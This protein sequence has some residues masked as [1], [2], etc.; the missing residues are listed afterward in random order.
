L[1]STEQ[2]SWLSRAPVAKAFKKHFGDQVIV[3]GQHVW[4]LAE[5]VAINFPTDNTEALRTLERDNRLDSGDI[6]SVYWMKPEWQRTPNQL[7]A[8]LK[9]E[10]RSMDVANTLIE[11]GCRIEYT[12]SNVKRIEE[13]PMQCLKCQQY[14]HIA[15][16][17]SAPANICSHCGGTH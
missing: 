15:T 7:Q 9:L 13:D 10:L 1:G 14:G 3:K 12:I 5:R 16:K 4:V 17:C 2:A 6:L 11:S 8:H